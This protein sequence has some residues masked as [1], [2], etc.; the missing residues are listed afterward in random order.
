MEHKLQPPTDQRPSTCSTSTG[1]SP[2]SPLADPAAKS[3]QETQQ[4]IV[5]LSI[6]MHNIAHASGM[7]WYNKV[8]DLWPLSDCGL[9]FAY[10]RM[11][12]YSVIRST[13]PPTLSRMGND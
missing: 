11:L 7:V 9:N 1:S 10:T 6:A 4:L 2:A 12:T 3:N 13:Q 5:V 8:L